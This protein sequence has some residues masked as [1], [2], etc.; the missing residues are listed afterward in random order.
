[1]TIPIA[2]EIT[3]NQNF[4]QIIKAL[5]SQTKHLTMLEIGASNGLGSTQA[6]IQ[7]ILLRE[8]RHNVKLFCLELALAAFEELR[9]NTHMHDFV[10]CYQESSCAVADLP[11]WDD[12]LH[13]Y[14]SKKTYL[15]DYSLETVR[16][17]YDACLNYAVQAGRL[18]NGI[19]KIKAE[20]NIKN[21]DLVLI[22][23][24]EFTGEQDL[25]ST[26]GA[27]TIV[28]DDCM[29]YKCHQAF[30]MLMAHHS[31]HLVIANL[32]ER[33]GYAVFRRAY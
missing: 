33:H 15:N 14:T 25:C 13:F 32:D 23:G 6:F 5:A 8:D 10:K 18:E 19:Q 9:T 1:M 28:L 26:I 31:Y 27:K 29:T 24:S 20:N 30:Q 2:P 12:V 7:G 21:F 22:D 17:W 4:Y 11:D 16:G 3:E